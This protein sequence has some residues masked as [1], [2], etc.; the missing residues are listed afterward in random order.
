MFNNPSIR[1]IGIDVHM[2]SGH[3]LW[4]AY[5]RKKACVYSFIEHVGLQWMAGVEAVACDMNSD[6]QQAFQ[7]KCPHI[8]VVFDFFISSGI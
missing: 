3:I 1:T 4:L 5:G 6:F 2:E 7:E 8:K